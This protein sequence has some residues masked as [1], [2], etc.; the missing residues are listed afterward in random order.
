MK[1]EHKLMLVPLTVPEENGY[2]AYSE[3][4]TP[5]YVVVDEFGKYICNLTKA[6]LDNIITRHFSTNQ[7]N[8]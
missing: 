5:H 8:R 6:E 2:I 4:L 1:I 3:S 7:N